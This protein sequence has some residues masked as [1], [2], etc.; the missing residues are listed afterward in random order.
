MTSS[1]AIKSVV[2]EIVAQGETAVLAA[3]I[4]GVFLIL[5]TA[6]VFLAKR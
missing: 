1:I 4:L 6:L 5:T 3:S 2:G